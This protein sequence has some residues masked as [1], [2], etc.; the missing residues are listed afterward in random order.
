MTRQEV[1][2]WIQTVG[3]GVLI[4]A[5]VAWLAHTS[6]T[7][8]VN[9]KMIE[10]AA[11]VLTGPVNDSMRPV[12]QWATKMLKHYSPVPFSDTTEAAFARY[13]LVLGPERPLPVQPQVAQVIVSPKSVTVLPTG[14]VHFTAFARSEF[15]DVIPVAVTWRA[16]SGSITPDGR[17]TAP[18]TPGDYT[19]IASAARIAD[20]VLVHVK[21]P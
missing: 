21:Q 4:P 11:Q 5:A 14:E 9:A 20:T 3:V 18:N 1:R 2:E 8:E 10:V 19:V 6:S 7:R 12:R 15:G 13:V 17:Y 16:T